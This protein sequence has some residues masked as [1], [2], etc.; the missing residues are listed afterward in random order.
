MVTSEHISTYEHGMLRQPR[1]YYARASA[2]QCPSRRRV[3][4]SIV[5]L[6]FGESAITIGN[7]VYGAR[8]TDGGD[9]RSTK[10]ALSMLALKKC[11]G[12][13]KDPSCD[14]A[15]GFSGIAEP[16]LVHLPRISCLLTRHLPTPPPPTPPR[17]PPSPPP[18]FDIDPGRCP[19]GGQTYFIV[20]PH[21][22]PSQAA[23]QTWELNIH[24]NTWYNGMHVIIDFPS[25]QHADHALHVNAVKPPEVARLIAVTKHSAIIELLDTAARDFQ[26]EAL[27]DVESL[28]VMCDLSGVRPFPP[29]PPP[30]PDEGEDH[31]SEGDY[32]QQIEDPEDPGREDLTHA[33]NKGEQSSLDDEGPMPPAPPPLAR[34]PSLPTDSMPPTPPPPSKQSFSPLRF[35]LVCVL[36]VGVAAVAAQQHPTGAAKVAQR[37]R[38]LRAKCSRTPLGRNLLTSVSKRPVGRK[39]LLLEA[40]YLGMAAFEPSTD[41]ELRD[42][43]VGVNQCDPPKAL[44]DNHPRPKPRARSKAKTKK[45][46]EQEQ[47][48]EREC[49]PLQPVNGED[50]A[51][52]E[53]V[54]P[55]DDGPQT[56]ASG[57]GTRFVVRLGKTTAESVLHLEDVQT[58]KE[59]QTLVSQAC[60][61]LDVDMAQGFRMLLV[62]VAGAATTVGKSCTIERIRSANQIE[63]VPKDPRL[64][65]GQQQS[66]PA[67]G[68]TVQGP[69]LGAVRARPR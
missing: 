14:N 24:L 59:V 49:E 41:L 20:A 44:I 68:G 31:V 29:P 40:R 50:T 57:E 51:A 58:L 2:P 9:G 11:L 19:K 43:L 56:T 12:M 35:F 45:A 61:H 65:P 46:A 15:F 17:P 47:E 1:A 6:D 5:T 42:V 21:Q 64:K 39:L 26:F 63:L 34:L 13:Y 36:I 27:G 48:A 4:Q 8:V 37:L 69:A 54:G 67:S 22:L 33:P 23:L 25:L 66:R 7:D 52:T 55:V 30:S 53:E 62:D 60:D 3:M 28:E 16:P 38:L 32:D 18:G 10:V